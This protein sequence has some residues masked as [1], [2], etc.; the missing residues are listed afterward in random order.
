MTGRRSKCVRACQRGRYVVATFDVR[1]KLRGAGAGSAASPGAA[2]PGARL[3]AAGAF[4]A[5]FVF[6]EWHF[7]FLLSLLLL[8]PL[9]ICKKVII[10]AGL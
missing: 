7:A 6:D 1:R 5:S 2:S 9:A 8:L 3:S 10:V 4:A